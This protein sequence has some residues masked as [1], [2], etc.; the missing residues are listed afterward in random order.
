MIPLIWQQ[1]G[2]NPSP[3]FNP[4][5]N[6]YGMG[7]FPTAYFNGNSSVEGGGA[8]SSLV[9]A[10]TARYN[11]AV[12]IESPMS[13]LH[14][15]EVVDNTVYLETEVS[16]EMEIS[17]SNNRI[18]FMLTQNFDGVQ[19]GN[20]FASVTRYHEQPFTLNST[21]ET[22]IFTQEIALNPAW[23]LDNTSIVVIV[24]SFS[25]DRPIHQALQRSLY[26]EAGAPLNLSCEFNEEITPLTISLTWDEPTYYNVDLVGYNVYRNGVYY[27]D[28]FDTSFVDPFVTLY[29]EYKYYVTAVYAGIE[30]EPSNEVTIGV[31]SEND[32][33]AYPYLAE[34]RYNY[35]NPFNPSTTI[36]FVVHKDSPILLEVFNLRGQLIS[37]LVDGYYT[38]GEHSVVWEG[39]DSNGSSVG[40]GVYFYRLVSGDYVDVQRMVLMK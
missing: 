33:V 25:G 3:N 7:G 6:G 14:K 32:P 29:Q 37:T 12:E 18:I 39:L 38:S 2:P 15:H 31:A 28:V 4:R 8:I 10:Y 13:I 19:N 22:A 21:G 26:Y 9:N 1:D 36:D 16:M 35:P 5:A 11:N 34:L 17:T 27:T 20:Y 23:N 30:S 24:Q 40:S